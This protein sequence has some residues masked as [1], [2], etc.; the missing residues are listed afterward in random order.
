MMNLSTRNKRPK[1][2]IRT[3]RLNNEKDIPINH[4]MLRNRSK[5]RTEPR[6]RH[7]EVSRTIHPSDLT[8]SS[9][10]II[11]V[12]ISGTRL[13]SSRSFALFE[14]KTAERRLRPRHGLSSL[15]LRRRTG[16]SGQHG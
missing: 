10:V 12:K 7:Q 15:L 6:I 8:N 1:R 16:A 3:E 14:S 9:Q 11:I 4:S 13:G 2:N 5:I